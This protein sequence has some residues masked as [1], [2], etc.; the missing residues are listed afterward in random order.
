[1]VRTAKWSIIFAGAIILIAGATYFL[2]LKGDFMNLYMMPLNA[3]DEY[4]ETLR[5]ELCK[6]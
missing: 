2:V 1:M 5:Q 3:D 4:F 6:L